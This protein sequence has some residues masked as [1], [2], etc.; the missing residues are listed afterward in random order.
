MAGAWHRTYMTWYGSGFYGQRTACGQELT[1]PFGP[2]PGL[3]GV[4]MHSWVRC[5]TRIVIEVNGHRVRTR[6]VDHCGCAPGSD[7]DM[8]AQTAWDLYGHGN[9]HSGYGRYRFR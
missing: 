1:S 8:T 7:I 2:G 4:A 3:R 6:V 9:Q 5:G